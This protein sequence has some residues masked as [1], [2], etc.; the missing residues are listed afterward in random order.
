MGSTCVK[1]YMIIVSYVYKKPII[2]I[3][4]RSKH[5]FQMCKEDGFTNLKF[6]Y[7]WQHD[8]LTKLGFIKSR[9]PKHVIF[10][11]SCKLYHIPYLTITNYL[12]PPLM[13]FFRCNPIIWRPHQC[14]HDMF[15]SSLCL[16]IWVIHVMDQFPKW[17][18]GWIV[19][20]IVYI[21][22]ITPYDICQ[23]AH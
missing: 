19:H 6:D 2:I 7:T 17:H 21:P 11:R 23:L 9:S 12:W 20:K 13:R 1:L 8:W 3:E 16:W 5:K 15:N 22:I 18:L 14:A 10:E 4:H